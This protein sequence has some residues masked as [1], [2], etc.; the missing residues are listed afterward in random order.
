[1]IFDNKQRMEATTSTSCARRKSHTDPR[2][3]K[4]R[5][6]SNGRRASFPA[7]RKV[8]FSRYDEIVDTFHINDLKRITNTKDI[9]FSEQETEEMKHNCLNVIG[10]MESGL[11]LHN[12][13]E[14][15]RGLEKQLSTSRHHR[16]QHIMEA[17]LSVLD[18][19]ELQREEGINDPELLAD[20][21]FSRSY[22]SG[23]DAYLIGL[24]DEQAVD[25]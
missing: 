5:R 20:I 10:C 23:L 8:R 11:P 16:R 18:E 13:Q 2:S 9:W 3:G 21:Y 1:M 6:R 14:C 12:E 4:G 7:S 15:T 22:E 24:E 17:V 25:F 19:Q